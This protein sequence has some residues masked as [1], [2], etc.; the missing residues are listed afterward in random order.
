MLPCTKIVLN[1]FLANNEV[2]PLCVVLPKMSRYVKSFD[3][4]KTMCFFFKDR[5]IFVKYKEIW[6]EIL[7]LIKRKKNDSRAVFGDTGITY[8]KTKINSCN[9]QVTTN[10]HGKATQKGL[11]YLC[12]SEIVIDSVF[13]LGKSYNPQKFLKKK[14]KIIHQG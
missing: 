5:I 12:M 2:T 4:T 13:E 7:K 8:L 6:N 9:G 1:I 14:D 11:K 10:F 3:N